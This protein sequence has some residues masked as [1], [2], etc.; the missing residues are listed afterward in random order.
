M[1]THTHTHTHIQVHI[2]FTFALQLPSYISCMS[3]LCATLGDLV[4]L[5]FSL[6]IREDMCSLS[7]CISRKT[8]PLS[9]SSHAMGIRIKQYRSIS[10]FNY[11]V[12]NFIVSLS[13]FLFSLDLQGE[14]NPD[15]SVKCH[16]HRIFSFFTFSTL[17]EAKQQ[18]RLRVSLF[19]LALACKFLLKSGSEI[20]HT[21][22]R[23]DLFHL[24]LCDSRQM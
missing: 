12:D 17:W 7:R 18:Q 9:P 20:Y 19:S 22:Q 23:K 15:A 13:L 16:R 11:R 21:T 4:T 8:R 1:H 6:S 14:E 3:Y 5:L 24:P 10:T 2:L